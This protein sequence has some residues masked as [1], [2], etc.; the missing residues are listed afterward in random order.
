MPTALRR[1]T[2]ASLDSTAAG[3][4]RLADLVGK[5]AQLSEAFFT[6]GP[7]CSFSYLYGWGPPPLSVPGS[8]SQ[9]WLFMPLISLGLLALEERVGLT[10]WS[11]G[12]R[13][14]VGGDQAS[15]WRRE[16]SEAVQAYSEWFAEVHGDQRRHSNVWAILSEPARWSGHRDHLTGPDQE[17]VTPS[18]V[19]GMLASLL[20]RFAEWSP[21]SINEAAA[22]RS[23]STPSHRRGQVPAQR[24]KDSIVAGAHALL[25]PADED[26]ESS[27]RRVTD[28]I[29]RHTLP[30]QWKAVTS[31]SGE[32]YYWNRQSSITTWTHPFADITEEIVT[33]LRDCQSTGVA[34][35]L[36][37]DRLNYWARCWHEA[38]C[39]ELSRWRS[40]TA[41]D[42]AAYFYRMP[43]E[44]S[45]A[46]ADSTTWEDPRQVQDTRL[47]FQV[48]VLAQLLS[49][50]APDI[51]G[52]PT[53]ASTAGSGAAIGAQG[54]EAQRRQA[55]PPRAAAS[56]G[57][58]VPQA[59]RTTER[60]S[61]FRSTTS[62]SS[63]SSQ[64]GTQLATRRSRDGR[65]FSVDPLPA[66]NSCGFHGLGISREEAARLLLKGRGDQQVIEWVTADL[67]QFLAT[68]LETGE[69]ERLPSAIGEDD[70]LWASIVT[71]FA[72]QNEVDEGRRK[73]LQLLRDVASDSAVQEEA[74]KNS[75]VASAL[76]VAGG[77]VL[78]ALETLLSALKAE[79]GK[80]PSGPSK[81]RLMH[82]LMQC[83]TEA[84]SLTA[85]VEANNQADKELLRHCRVHF[86][87]Y[88]EW[89]GKDS[90]FWLSFLRNVSGES[91]G[92]LLDALA[93]VT[94][95]TVRVWSEVRMQNGAGS[96]LPDLE[97]VH[98]A[99]HGGKEIDLFFQQNRN[100]YDRLLPCK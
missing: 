21:S 61:L 96:G 54:Q 77:D 5:D 83:K 87:D 16:A 69:R 3:G 7:L 19:M 22:H 2:E 99:R 27:R 41:G 75:V 73:T 30:P 74:K 12:N 70:K 52:G 72:A 25:A 81:L 76:S 78:E 88:V 79:A 89:M 100:H 98:E 67:K 86:G 46:E 26:E 43:E 55:A 33:A 56:H 39:H 82:R 51:A 50:P 80:M 42:G 60:R 28:A 31:R 40:V 47:R 38:A 49:L 20:A 97:L 32:V 63:S 65:M 4:S 45:A 91:T 93:K 11:T 29:K 59:T 6:R 84:K 68:F 18:K 64:R 94:R 17:A 15:F 13:N 71:Y 92:G 10:P 58:S 57:P 62:T 44:N 1:S 48:D 9:S 37:Q 8:R 34:S 85:L 66:D 23:Y 53:A 95:L 35:R 24:T 14:R 90:S 36:R